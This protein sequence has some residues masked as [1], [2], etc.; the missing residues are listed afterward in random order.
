MLVGMSTPSSSP[1]TSGTSTLRARLPAEVQA[2]LKERKSASIDSLRS[3][4]NGMGNASLKAAREER[5]KMLQALPP[6]E[7]VRME[8]TLKDMER[9]EAQR[10]DMVRRKRQAPSFRE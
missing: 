4:K 10:A 7:R 9:M 1:D 5:E 3:G 2:K 8:A 6:Q